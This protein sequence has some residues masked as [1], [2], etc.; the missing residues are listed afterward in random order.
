MGKINIKE[1]HELTR[2]SQYIIKGAA[3][4]GVLW[5][6]VVVIMVFRTVYSNIFFASMNPDLQVSFY[7]YDY[8]GFFVIL[9]FVF[10]L[11]FAGGAWILYKHRQQGGFKFKPSFKLPPRSKVVRHNKILKRKKVIKNRR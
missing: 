8:W 10:L 3:I 2:E 6:V 4:G 9:L 11:I 5:L 1:H 7:P